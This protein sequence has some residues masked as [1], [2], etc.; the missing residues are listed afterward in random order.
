M[1]FTRKARNDNHTLPAGAVF[2]DDWDGR[3]RP[4]RIVRGPNRDVDGRVTVRTSAA[5]WADG[6]IDTGPF[7]PRYVHVET[8]GANGGVLTSSQARQ[9][10][11]ALI[12]AADEIDAWA[13]STPCG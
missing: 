9:V 2:A 8:P 1:N 3:N 10:A 4:Y 5:Q 12:A 7:E 6:R 13:A 11:R